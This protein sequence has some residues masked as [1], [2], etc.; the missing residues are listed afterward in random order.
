MTAIPTDGTCQAITTWRIRE[1]AFDGTRLDGLAI[2]LFVRWP[3]AIHQGNGRGI[4]FIDERATAEQR[5]ALEAI[6]IGKAGS[7]GPFEIFA[8]TYS[9]PATVIYGPI[10]VEHSGKNARL[11][12]G[13]VARAEFAPIRS[14]MDNSE[15][16]VRM[17]LPNG[18]IW[19]D[20]AIVNTVACEVNAAGLSFRHENSNAFLS[21]VEYN[22]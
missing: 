11:R 3:N 7:G 15:A 21:E 13:N 1:G 20:S 6:G 4:V 10:Q 2:A 16:D 9:A 8:S 17:L 22:R 12:F 18:F 14:S 19:K 5:R